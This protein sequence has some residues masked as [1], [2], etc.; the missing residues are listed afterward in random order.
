VV[1]GHIRCGRWRSLIPGTVPR[2][3][4]RH[5]S[6]A[7]P[8]STNNGINGSGPRYSRITQEQAE[9]PVPP[10]GADHRL[11]LGTTKAGDPDHVG[12]PGI[13]VLATMTSRLPRGFLGLRDGSGA[14]TSNTRPARTR[15]D[16]NSK[17][18]L[19]VFGDFNHP[20]SM[21]DSKSKCGNA[22]R[23]LNKNVRRGRETHLC[24]KTSG[25]AQRVYPQN[26]YL[27]RC[28][29]FPYHDLHQRA[30]GSRHR[31]GAPG[32]SG[33]SFF[34]FFDSCVFLVYLLIVIE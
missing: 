10:G 5:R 27:T 15:K 26:H 8:S 24:R 34:F 2:T 4:C 17:R 30:V 21:P 22:E 13:D 9:G 16:N 32:P 12:K 20:D 19:E 31:H 18:R 23:G 6:K 25:N 14:R 28:L 7:L 33:C 1:A 29:V 3:P 11:A